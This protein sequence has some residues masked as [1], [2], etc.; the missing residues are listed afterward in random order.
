M[1]Y[2]VIYCLLLPATPATI[3]ILFSVFLC[4]KWK[5]LTAQGK[6]PWTDKGFATNILYIVLSFLFLVVT[7][8]IYCYC[9]LA[10]C[11]RSV[12]GNV[13]RVAPEALPVRMGALQE[14]PLADD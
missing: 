13:T 3:L 4:D 2:N 5:S 1:K 10:D 6:D 9:A 8:Y 14:G 7:T 12:R 11:I